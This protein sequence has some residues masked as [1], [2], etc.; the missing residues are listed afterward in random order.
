MK[1]VGIGLAGLGF[2]AK[3]HSRALIGIP[4]AK[5]VAAWSKFPEEHGKFKEFTKKAGFEIDD[6]YTELEKMLHDPNVDA[7]ICAIPYR[8][9]EPIAV[10]VIRSGKPAILECP[11]GETPEVI[12]RLDK[13]AKE[14]GVR[15]MPGHCYRFAKGFRKSKELIDNGE[16]GEPTFVHFREFVPAD[17]LAR[18]W[19]P[20]SWIWNKE[21]GGPIP[22]MTVF[23]MDMARW[24]LGSEPV[25]MYASVKWQDLKQ[26][27]T[28]GYTVANV[29]KFKNDVTWVNEFSGSVAS[30]MGPPVKMEILGEKGNAV[31]LDGPE[32]VILQTGKNEQREWAFDLTRPERWGHMPQDE[33]FVKSV[34]IGKDEPTVKL[35]DA[36]KALEMSLAAIESSKKGVPIGFG[37]D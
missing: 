22:T 8:F 20:T 18:Q 10:E 29:I 37:W 6:Y 28:L 11:P 36:K 24:I 13:L 34:V 30:A 35:Q 26:F 9:I 12:A 5:I 15:V 31:V 25:S 32:K 19:P 14:K 27:G 17:S 33:Y 23:C 2:M 7:V 4:E 1:Q 16:I 3:V 21:K